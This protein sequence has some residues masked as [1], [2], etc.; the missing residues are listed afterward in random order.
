[1]AMIMMTVK[2]IVARFPMPLI[3][4]LAI[5]AALPMAIV[6]HPLNLILYPVIAIGLYRRDR[7]KHQANPSCTSPPSVKRAIGFAFLIVWALHVVV[8]TGIGFALKGA[9][10]AAQSMGL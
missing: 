8:L 3:P 2:S 4:V 10:N 7:A 1:M 6:P 5:V 9:A